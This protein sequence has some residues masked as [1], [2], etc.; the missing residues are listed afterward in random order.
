MIRVLYFARLRELLDCADES[1]PANDVA[2]VAELVSR[3]QARG[4]VWATAFDRDKGLLCAVNQEMATL[5]SSIQDNDEVGFF[6]PVT[7]G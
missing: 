4:G 1:I 7:G 2:T 5:D 6:P 3:L